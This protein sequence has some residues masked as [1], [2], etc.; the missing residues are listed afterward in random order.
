[1]SDSND[2]PECAAR[3]PGFTPLVVP[4]TSKLGEYLEKR[5]QDNAHRNR[6]RA[7]LMRGPANMRRPPAKGEMIHGRPKKFRYVIDIPTPEEIT[8]VMEYLI[9]KG[10]TNHKL[11][12]ARF[13]VF[14]VLTF[15]GG[16][17]RTEAVN[18][19]RA[20]IDF[21]RNEVTV[22][23]AKNDDRRV[24]GIDDRSM[25]ILDAYIRYMDAKKC[26]VNLPLIHKIR[27]KTLNRV[28]FNESAVELE[29]ASASFSMVARSATIKLGLPNKRWNPHSMRHACAISMMT[30]NIPLPVISKQ[31]GHKNIFYTLQYLRGFDVGDLGQRMK[32][33]NGWGVSVMDIEAFLKRIS[34]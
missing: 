11:A 16:L 21:S 24:V 3:E 33:R 6:V 17:R 8:K 12:R 19:T 23:H 28:G 5:K 30:E 2:L 4:P 31:L 29:T 34:R 32:H 26:D 20:D 7:R 9:S 13:L 10:C 22:R 18:V 27:Q 25:E 15:R 1:M 14:C